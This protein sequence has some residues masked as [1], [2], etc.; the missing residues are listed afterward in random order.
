MTPLQHSREHSACQQHSTEQI[1]VEQADDIV[2]R[3]ARQRSPPV[4]TRIVDEHIDP[5]E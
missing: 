2:R 1:D 4:R 5:T 3:A